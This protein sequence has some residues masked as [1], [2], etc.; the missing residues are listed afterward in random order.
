MGVLL[1][2]MCS[3][4]FTAQSPVPSPV[5]RKA[6]IIM[7]AQPPQQHLTLDF[8]MVVANKGPSQLLVDRDKG[9]RGK[10]LSFF[11]EIIAIQ[12]LALTCQYKVICSM[13]L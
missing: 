3:V 5:G 8:N 6:G 12:R 9:S 10:L 13:T 4:Q 11:L 2:Y 1:F 7:E